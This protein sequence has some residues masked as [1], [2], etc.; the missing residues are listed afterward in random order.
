[1]AQDFQ[2]VNVFFGEQ[3]DLFLRSLSAVLAALFYRHFG[4]LPERIFDYQ[5]DF[6]SGSPYPVHR[7]FFRDFQAFPG[8]PDT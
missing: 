5:G 1:M 2:H 8:E 4:C 7:A 6:P 3:T